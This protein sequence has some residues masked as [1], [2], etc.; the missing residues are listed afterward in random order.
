MILQTSIPTK[1]TQCFNTLLQILWKLSLTALTVH[2]TSHSILNGIITNDTPP[3][4]RRNW[5]E[6]NI[7][8]PGSVARYI[9]WI[10]FGCKYLD[11]HCL[12]VVMSWSY[13]LLISAVALGWLSIQCLCHL[14][15]QP[16][17]AFSRWM[18]TTAAEIVASGAGPPCYLGE[19]MYFYH[20][21]LELSRSC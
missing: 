10:H 5:N 15:L 4:S 19:E 18:E 6:K 3:S 9:L 8:E 14:Q 11:M 16:E 20:Y 1:G 2:N 7:S 21:H 17:D 13:I 12:H